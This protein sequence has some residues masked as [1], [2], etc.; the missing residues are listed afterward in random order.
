MQCTIQKLTIFFSIR[1]AAIFGSDDD[2]RGIT[3]AQA[4]PLDLG[5]TLNSLKNATITK[6]TILQ[7]YN[8]FPVPLGVSVSCLPANEVCDTGDRY[9]FTTIPNTSVNT[10]IKLYEAGECQT[11]AAEWRRN[12][13]RFNSSNLETQVN[14]Y[15]ELKTSIVNEY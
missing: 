5:A 15:I 13:A 3:D 11:Q 1:Q 8:T 9:T 12:Y 6:A 14:F 10:P 7:S 2:M 4:G